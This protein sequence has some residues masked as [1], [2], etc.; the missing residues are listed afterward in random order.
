MLENNKKKLISPIR[1]QLPMKRVLF[2]LIPIIIASA[3][4]FG[5]KGIVLLIITNFAGFLTEYIFC[6]YY[7]KEPVSSSVFVTATLFTLTL[8]PTIPVWIAVVGVVVAVLFGKMVFGG[9]GRN[10]FNPA[11]VGRAFIYVSFGDQMTSVWVNPFSGFDGLTSFVSDLITKATPINMAA[12]MEFTSDTFLPLLIGNT[13]GCLGE[14]SAVLIILGGI[15]L[16]IKKAANYRIVFSGLLS[17]LIFQTLFWKLGIVNAVNPIFALFSGGFLFGLFF[18]ATDPVSSPMTNSG[19]WI[20]GF[21][22]GGLTVV[23]RI[24]SSWAEGTMF[25]ILLGNMFAHI[26]DYLIGISGKRMKT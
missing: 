22:V 9:F 11:I 4:F 10:P 25:A 19:R 26:I 5:W 2:S 13:S 8:P 18:M 7:Y 3:F 17:L 23:I 6:R 15:Y 1:W 20:F 16:I 21:L 24:F 14:T 12:H